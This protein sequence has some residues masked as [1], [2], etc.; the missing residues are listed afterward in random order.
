MLGINLMSLRWN[1]A[2]ALKRTKAL[3][4]SLFFEI[5]GEQEEKEFHIEN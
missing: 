2:F 3:E 1:N 4:I 5:M